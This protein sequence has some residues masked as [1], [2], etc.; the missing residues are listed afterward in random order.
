MACRAATNPLSAV[1][2][3]TYSETET[4]VVTVSLTTFNWCT[5]KCWILAVDDV[6]TST[7][8]VDAFMQEAVREVMSAA[9]TRAFA[10][11]KE[12][13]YTPAPVMLVTDNES[14]E[15]VVMVAL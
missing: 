14:T 8:P 11:V 6:K 3:V 1:I 5:V 7:E 2:P 13:M 4:L 10:A 12:A 15:P 9:E